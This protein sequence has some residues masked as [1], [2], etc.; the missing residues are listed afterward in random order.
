MGG[1][2]ALPAYLGGG[3]GY[4]APRGCIPYKARNKPTHGIKR[5]WRCNCKQRKRKRLI[6]HYITCKTDVSH[7]NGKI[8]VIQTPNNATQ[9]PED[10]AD[11]HTSRIPQPTYNLLFHTTPHRHTPEHT[12]HAAPYTTAPRRINPT[13]EYCTIHHGTIQ[14][15][16]TALHLI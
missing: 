7:V 16:Y 10:S 14:D 13:W 11:A 3:G 2:G 9:Q 5:A 8:N 6:S 4:D 15:I 12:T 1:L